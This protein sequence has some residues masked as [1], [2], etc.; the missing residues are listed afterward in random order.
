MV[1]NIMHKIDKPFSFLLKKT[2]METIIKKIDLPCDM[3]GEIY[4]Y[5][6][7]EKGYTIEEMEMIEQCKKKSM[8]PKK[9]ITVE[10][11][12]WHKLGVSISW[13]RGGGVYSPNISLYGGPRNYEKQMIREAF[14]EN[15]I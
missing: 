8:W 6:Y 5:C 11:W 4:K 10:L 7:N 9:R 2:I 14:E 3:K 13:L 1:I 15:I 12:T